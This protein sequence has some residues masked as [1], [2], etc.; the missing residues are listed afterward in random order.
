MTH[1]NFQNW[2]NQKISDDP[3]VILAGKLE[4]LRL[5]LTDAM[6]QLREK[7]GL[8][9]AQLAEKLGVQ[10]AAVSKLE[11]AL[12]DRKLES[13]LQYLHTLDAELLMAVKQGDEIYQV[14]DNDGVMLVD[15][16][17]EVAIKAAAEGMTLRE[18]VHAAIKN[19]SPK[20]VSGLES[21][22]KSDEEV[23]VR[24]RERLGGKSIEE[25][26]R[27]L[28]K[29]YSLPKE[30]RV[31]ALTTFLGGGVNAVGATRS[32]TDPR[33]ITEMSDKRELLNLAKN[34]EKK[35]DEI[36]NSY[37]QPTLI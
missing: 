26:A 23:A 22:L 37:P 14:S 36:V 33:S 2:L 9:Q 1:Y 10:Q 3:E 27:E 18:Y 8:T 19:F 29:C 20:T 6:R 25:I 11:S 16:P 31:M 15:V 35:L 24:V 30:D 17:E 5:Y 13:V 28:E 21:F 7:A 4:Y 12:K 32:S 34:L